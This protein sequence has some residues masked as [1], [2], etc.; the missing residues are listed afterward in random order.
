M[1]SVQGT[2][3]RNVERWQGKLPLH[4][5]IQK[6]SEGIRALREKVLNPDRLQEIFVG[7]IDKLA[8]RS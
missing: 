6:L 7:E 2:S 3:G 5:Q 4:F 1:N 8:K